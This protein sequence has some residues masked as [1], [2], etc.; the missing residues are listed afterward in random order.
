MD[1]LTDT[2]QVVSTETADRG[3]LMRPGAASDAASILRLIE[4]N[5]V[6]GH[7]LPRTHEEVASHAERFVVLEDDGVIVGFGELA[8]L[9]RAVAEVRSLVV[10]E[11]WRGRGLGTRLVDELSARAR[12]AGFSLLCAF[13][14]DP[15]HFIR[16]GFS[17]V[18]HVW[19]PEKV[20]LDCTGC[21]RF[22]RCGQHA[23]ALPLTTAN[24]LPTLRRLREPL[25]VATSGSAR[26]SVLPPV[27]LRVIA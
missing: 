13:T 5:L 11:Q 14:H 9:S 10:D 6:A 7:L 4:T 16:L 18:P 24:V 21:A 3:P 2:L 27:R 26:Q 8:P 15:H 23:M 17:M 12:R 22:R 20:A 1:T 19:F 25:T